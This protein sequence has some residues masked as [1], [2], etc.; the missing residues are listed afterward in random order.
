ML[1]K[2]R[3]ELKKLRM[4]Q[5]KIKKKLATAPEGK[6]KCKI[7]RGN[8]QYY[9]GKRYLGKEE[10]KLVIQLAET[11]YY[12]KLDKEMSKY[13]KALVTV[14]DCLQKEKLQNIYR[15][16]HPARKVLVEPVYRPVEEI[17]EEF[18]AIEHETKGFDDSDQTAYYTIKGERVRSKSE[19]II[20]DELYRHGIPYKYEFPM[21]LEGWNRKVV[22]Y[23]DFTALNKRTG[24]KWIIEH[25]GMMDREGYFNNSMFK[26]DT[27]EKN[28]IL[29][30][31]DL[32]V[33]H[34]TSTM[35]LNTKIVGQYINEY[36]E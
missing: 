17:I 4:V 18:E 3:E 5:E 6:L 2:A 31:R 28:D 21:E 26:L 20:A 9:I 24:K 14:I 32:I 22:V 33:L 27:Y 15:K 1:N 13:A 36:L 11:E 23:P 8:N 34:E 16:L 30:G 35:P 25:L 7:C 12:E 29:L 19:K 10:R